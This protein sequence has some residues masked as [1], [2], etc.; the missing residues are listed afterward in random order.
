M[1]NDSDYTLEVNAVGRG[2][3]QQGFLHY[4]KPPKPLITII[5]LWVLIYCCELSLTLSFV[6]S[7]LI[8][9]V[10]RI[11]LFFST[12]KADLHVIQWSGGKIA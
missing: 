5:T 11:S 8:L 6:F 2:L 10:S 4:L 7:C 12:D 3:T 9:I 1:V